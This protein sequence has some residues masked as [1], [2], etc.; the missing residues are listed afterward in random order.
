MKAFW[1][2]AEGPDV[3]CSARL[4]RRCKVPC[5]SLV[6]RLAWSPPLCHALDSWHSFPARVGHED[7]AARLNALTWRVRKL[8]NLGPQKNPHPKIF[9]NS[10]LYPAS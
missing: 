8:G 6:I 5:L 9:E 1:T 4:A 2:F 7:I 3:D 10:T